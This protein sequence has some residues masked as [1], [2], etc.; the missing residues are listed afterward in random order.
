MLPNGSK[1]YKSLVGAIL[2]LL[3]VITVT[4]YGIYK[5]QLLIDKEETSLSQRI[6]EGYFDKNNHTFD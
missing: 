4:L 1:E 6:E 3:T 2:T 5:W